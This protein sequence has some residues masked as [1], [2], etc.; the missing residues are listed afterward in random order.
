MNKNYYI[1]DIETLKSC[2]TYTGLN[3]DTAEI[4]TY[5]LHK[6]K[7]ELHDLIQHLETVKYGIGFNNIFFDYPVLH[8][9]IENYKYF[10]TISK[11]D[12]IHAIYRESQRIINLSDDDF[13]SRISYKNFK[14]PQ[15]DLYKIWHYNNKGRRTSL[16]S[17]QISM[18]FP[19][20][21]EMPLEHTKDDITLEEVS[22]ILKY[23]LNDVIATFEFYKLSKDKIKLRTDIS[24]AYKISALNYSDSKIGETIIFKEIIKKTGIDSNILKS[25]RTYRNKIVVKD[26]LFD[27]IKFET[28]ELKQIHSF[29]KDVIIYPGTKNN[30]SKSILFKNVLIDYGIGGI[31]G[32]TRAGI[33]ESDNDYVIMSADVASLYPNIGIKY[34]LYL[35]HLG[36]IFCDIY[37]NILDKRIKAK[38]LKNNILSDALKLALNATY[39]KSNEVNSFLYDPQYTMSITINGQLLMS[40]LVEKLSCIPDSQIYMINTDGLEI[41]I[42][43]I[44][45]EMYFN[46]C[47]EWEKITKFTLEYNEYNKISIADVNNYSCIDT[48]SKIKNKGR[49]EIDKLVGSEPAYH[50]DNSFKIIPIALENYIYRNIPIEDTIRNHTNIYDFCGRQKFTKDSHGE[51]HSIVYR[52][53]IPEHVKNITQKN[54][55]YYISTKGNPFIKCYS[56]GSTEKIHVGFLVQE[57]NNYVEKQISDYNINYSFYINEVNKELNNIKPR[58]LDLFI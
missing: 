26:I 44:Y 41:K 17:L 10:N 22:D 8:F 2:F 15:L 12:V 45:K 37:S 13:S 38:N 43:R 32:I 30:I 24:K 18:N 50:K 11:E 39:G 31:H 9:I 36:S 7:F 4:K 14:M 19:N 48:N 1:Y 33:Y 56:K 47:K 58:Q 55:R 46:I 54:T 6:D 42:P 3:I 52:N 25:K 34:K 35:E 49:F 5:I 21:M 20:V 27:N 16:K 57:F 51:I 28:P 23:N 40:M 29:F 53:G